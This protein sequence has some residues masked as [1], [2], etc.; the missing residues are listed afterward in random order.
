MET[1]KS[2][3][4]SINK[5]G[6]EI[7]TAKNQVE[8]DKG[9]LDSLKEQLSKLL[10][11]DDLDKASEIVKKLERDLEKLETKIRTLHSEMKQEWEW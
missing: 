10:G 8:R 9:R 3:V 1:I 7:T 6:Q 5:L 4:S 2:I 11:T